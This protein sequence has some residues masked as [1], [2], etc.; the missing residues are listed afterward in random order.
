MMGLFKKD[1]FAL[2]Q[3][4]A[5]NL[6]LVFVLY[7][8]MVVAMEVMFLIYFMIWVTG[9]YSLSTF[10]LDE[11]TGWRRYER[12][13]PVSPRQAVAAR[14]LTAV[15]MTAVG[16]AFGLAVGGVHSLIRHASMAELWETI[17]LVTGLALA[18]VA[19]MLPVAYRWGVE[20]ARNSFLVLFM[21]LFAGGYLLRRAQFVQ[22][23]VQ[24]LERLLEHG[25]LLPLLTLAAGFL[26]L[27]VSAAVS[28]AIYRRKE[29]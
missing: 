5:K 8:V 14:Y 9:F 15:V 11:A 16:V 10:T 27:I 2:K 17:P 25:P 28:C 3:M 6:L 19:L 1:L 4:Y 13:L 26:L 18:S 22:S 29:D 7:T 24:T 21:L 12:T 20:K 23:V